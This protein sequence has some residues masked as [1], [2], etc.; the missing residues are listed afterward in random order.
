MK[1]TR[2]VLKVVA[3]AL[4]TAAAVCTVVAFWDKITDCAVNVSDKIRSRRGCAE[5]CCIDEE[6]YTDWDE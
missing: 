5:G 1:M 6:D 3:L 2:F 4:A